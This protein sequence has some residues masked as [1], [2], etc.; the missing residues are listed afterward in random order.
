MKK[1]IMGFLLFSGICIVYAC[2]G[3]KSTAESTSTASDSVTTTP[4]NSDTSDTTK[5]SNIK[6]DTTNNNAGNQIVD[7]N[8]RDFVANASTGGIM[9][10]ELGKLAQLKAKS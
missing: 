3:D 4:G 7:Q 9:E 2:N 10:V 6:T 8:T 5:T 1:L